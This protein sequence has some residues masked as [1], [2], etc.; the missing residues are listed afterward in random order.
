MSTANS[1]YDHEPAGEPVNPPA[2]YEQPHD[3][4]QGYPPGVP[5]GQPYGYYPY[6][7]YPPPRPT[8]GMAVASMV[9][10]I[11]WM[12]WV[13]SI[14]ALIFG[15]IARKQIKERGESGEA[16]AIAGIVLGWLGVAALVAVIV[17]FAGLGVFAVNS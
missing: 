13:G 15:Y 17:L 9:L 7:A 14:L 1:G 3:P 12:Y 4:H 11:M 2:A 6:P 5:Y 10:G 16:M 8:N